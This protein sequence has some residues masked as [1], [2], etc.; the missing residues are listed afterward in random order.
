MFKVPEKYRVTEGRMKSHSIIGNNGLFRIAKSKRVVYW[1]IA[2]DGEEWRP[3]KGYEE[4][5]AVSNTGKVRALEKTVTFAHGGRRHHPQIELLPDKHHLYPR[6]TLCVDGKNE[7]KLIHRLVAEAFIDN[8]NNFPN[9]NHINGDKQNPVVTNLEWCTQEYNIHHAIENDMS[10]GF[11]ETDILEIKKLLAEGIDYKEI[12]KTF[13]KSRQTISDIKFGRHRDL[14]PEVPSKYTGL[15]LWEHV[16]VSL[17]YA[18]RCP[19]WQEMCF[20]KNIFWDEEDSVIQYHPAKKDYVNYHP[21]TLHLW[22]PIGFAI[23]TPPS[24]LVGPK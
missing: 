14:N 4:F 13:N 5:Y 17:I 19:T 9:V 21:H 12:A 6:V 15:S 8:P 16:S 1:V 20:I 3:I 10:I 23:P 24:I 11:K 22:N 7:K 18:D 2:S